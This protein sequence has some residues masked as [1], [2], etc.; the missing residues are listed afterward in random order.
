ME[1]KKISE[2]TKNQLRVIGL[3]GAY[4]FDIVTHWNAEEVEKM[5]HL[6]EAVINEDEF[7]DY[8]KNYFWYKRPEINTDDTPYSGRWDRIQSSDVLAIQQIYPDSIKMKLVSEKEK[9]DRIYKVKKVHDDMT[10]E[11][12]FKANESFKRDINYIREVE[13]KFNKAQELT[14][15]DGLHVTQL[16]DYDNYKYLVENT[17]EKYVYKIYADEKRERRLQ[18]EEEYLEKKISK[19]TNDLYGY[20]LQVVGMSM[21]PQYAPLMNKLGEYTYSEGSRLYEDMIDIAKEYRVSLANAWNLWKFMVLGD[22]ES[23][24]E[25]IIVDMV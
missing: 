2:D 12:F 22:M 15:I 8:D 16:D 9:L 11:E 4:D 19:F 3:L 14:D 5:S 17:C 6:H 7:N 1:N 24:Y 13:A 21:D 10:D 25:S 23:R 18:S 20:E